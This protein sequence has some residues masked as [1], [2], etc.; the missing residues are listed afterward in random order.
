VKQATPWPS[1]GVHYGLTHEQYFAPSEYRGQRI[2]SKS[3][4]G[5]FAPDPA[6]WKA[7]DDE[8]K[9]DVESDSI[10]WGTLIDLL[11]FRP[12]AFERSYAVAPT[13]YTSIPDQIISTEA[14]GLWGKADDEPAVEW[15]G[16]KK[17][18]I[19]WKKAREAEGFAVLTPKEI[20][21]AQTPKP[22]NWNSSTCQKWAQDIRTERPGCQIVTDADIAEARKAVEILQAHPGYQKL[23]TGAAFQVAMLAL[24]W[25]VPIR[26]ALDILPA[27]EGEYGDALADLKTCARMRSK[28][29]LQRHIFEYGYHIQAGLYLALWN[30]LNPQNQR[31]RFIFVFQSSSAP[32]EVVILQMTTDAVALGWETFRGWIAR[33]KECVESDLWPSKWEGIDFISLP[34][35]AFKAT[36][37]AAFA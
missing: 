9:A 24:Y 14:F 6:V 36:E 10:S 1:L 15:N 30:A 27:A 5:Q 33:W 11:A 23:T 22:W 13:T 18:C 31:T 25:G 16:R 34:D 19:E 4:G 7:L 21:Q 37:S 20:E 29:E 2:F 8:G 32:Y 26:A 28:R 35:F 17:E 12:K 3:L